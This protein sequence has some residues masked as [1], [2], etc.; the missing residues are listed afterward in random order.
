MYTAKRSGLVCQ[1]QCQTNKQT[2]CCCC[3]VSQWNSQ[4]TRGI[5]TKRRILWGAF[6]I[7]NT[8]KMKRRRGGEN[9]HTIR[10][11][12]TRNT[13]NNKQINKIPTKDKTQCRFV[14][15]F[16]LFKEENIAKFGCCWR[17]ND[18]ALHSRTSSTIKL[19]VYTTPSPPEW[20]TDGT[21]THTSEWEFLLRGGGRCG[22]GGG[23]EGGR[24]TGKGRRRIG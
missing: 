9:N 12:H 23:G 19:K 13:H 18:S 4:Y 5:K 1:C 8:I 10:T 7:S 20:R 11:L 17:S 15:Y 2:N 16:L 6:W 24:Q 22:G 21:H 3:C 14:F